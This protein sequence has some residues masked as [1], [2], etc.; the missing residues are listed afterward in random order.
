LLNKIC[1]GLFAFQ[2]CL[3]SVSNADDIENL[4]TKFA[5]GGFN[6]PTVTLIKDVDIYDKASIAKTKYLANL[7]FLLVRQTSW[8]KDLVL[9]H[10][11]EIAR[12]YNTDDCRILFH[13][14]YIVEADPYKGYTS[15]DWSSMY[16]APD[17]AVDVQVGR[18]IPADA[19]RP[20]VV[21]MESSAQGYS[22]YAGVKDKITD[23][24]APL[25]NT[26]WVTALI[27]TSTYLQRLPA[28][29]DPIAHELAHLF[30][31]M[32]FHNDLPEPN[33]LHNDF[34]KINDKIL[35]E[36]CVEFQKSEMVFQ[37]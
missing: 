21:L 16:P 2:L 29:Y 31:N 5:A 6:A 14:V 13:K 23:K 22:A 32:P 4:K 20:V 35:P 11:K 8:T 10:L 28:D 24:N 34:D 33:I 37:P 9:K 19:P 25:L 17:N 18:Q 27:N 1:M 36:Q 12:I 7:T 26:A 15:I 30:G 3:S